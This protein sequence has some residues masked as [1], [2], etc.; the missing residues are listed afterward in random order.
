MDKTFNE[1]GSTG[2]SA[3]S[4]LG[5]IFV[6]LKVLGYVSF[7]WWWVLCP[8]WAPVLLMFVLLFFVVAFDITV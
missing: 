5:I 1:T 6:V 7:S 2:V 8:F 4:L 3:L